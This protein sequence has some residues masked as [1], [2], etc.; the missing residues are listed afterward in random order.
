MLKA[1]L[2]GSDA[3]EDTG[4]AN[5]PDSDFSLLQLQS[6][7]ENDESADRIASLRTIGKTLVQ[8][9]RYDEA[10]EVFESLLALDPTSVQTQQSLARCLE[11]LGRWAEAVARYQL[12]L[13][14][15]P[16]RAD[17]LAAMGLCMLHQD[18]PLG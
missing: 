5:H 16:V 9:R 10:A 3:P 17:T 1:K 4:S 13:E 12:V 2:A 15:D 6:H 14:A 18:S 8:K 11:R 7:L